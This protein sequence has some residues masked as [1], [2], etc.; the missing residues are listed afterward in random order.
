M[1]NML[2]LHMAK[3]EESFIY[4]IY[5][6]EDRIAV[7]GR[8]AYIMYKHINTQIRALIMPPNA[9]IVIFF[10]P[11]LLFFE[12]FLEVNCIHGPWFI[13][14]VHSKYPRHLTE[15]VGHREWN[16]SSWIKSNSL[17]NCPWHIKNCLGHK[18]YWLI[19]FK[20]LWYSKS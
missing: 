15:N 5:V 8:T 6:W 14:W 19:G 17:W 20:L 1:N 18:K 3:W 10:F 12:F 4:D 9:K 16:D 2:Q 7:F 13:S 11:N